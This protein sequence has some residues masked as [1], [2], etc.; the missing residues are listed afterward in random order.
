MTQ[1]IP[2]RALADELL[3][4][5]TGNQAHRAART[6]VGGRERTMRQT[7]IA[8]AAGSQLAEHESPGEATL[9][10]VVGRVELK[11]GDESWQLAEGDFVEIPPMR[12]AVDAVDGSVILLTAVPDGHKSH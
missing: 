6:I 10:V 2:L 9:F 3:A 11:A 12:H 4:E 7:L 5:A 1:T 8:L